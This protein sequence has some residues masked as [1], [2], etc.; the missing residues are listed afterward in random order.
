MSEHHRSLDR[1]LDR[2]H[3][4][5]SD[6]VTED[7]VPCPDCGVN[8]D[9]PTLHRDGCRRILPRRHPLQRLQ[10]GPPFEPWTRD[11]WIELEQG[12]IT[13]PEAGQP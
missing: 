7:A 12:R 6:V 3:R 2:V 11:H 5:E 13:P 1:A 8:P 9:D 10:F 4:A